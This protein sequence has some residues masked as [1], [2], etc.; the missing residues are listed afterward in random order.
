MRSLSVAFIGFPLAFVGQYAGLRYRLSLCAR[1]FRRGIR[2]TL[3]G[4]A[5]SFGAIASL[6]TFANAMT[7]QAS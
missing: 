2:G 3:G 7:G 6:L 1:A 5:W 4:S